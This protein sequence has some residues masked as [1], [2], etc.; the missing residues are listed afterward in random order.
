MET[1]PLI[2]ND[3]DKSF[4]HAHGQ[5]E[6]LDGKIRSFDIQ[7]SPVE[8]D[9]R[10]RIALIIQETTDRDSLKVLESYNHFKNKLLL[11]LSHELRTP[12]NGAI[13]FL[14][15]ASEDP[16]LPAHIKKELLIP[17]AKSNLLLMHIVND[18]LD[19]CQLQEN[20]LTLNL[21]NKSLQETVEKAVYLVQLQA[22]RKHLKLLIDYNITGSAQFNTDHER[23]MQVVLNL[24]NNSLKFTYKGSI[25]LSIQEKKALDGER[26]VEV[27]VADT[28]IGMKEEVSAKLLKMLAPAKSHEQEASE[29]STKDIG[30]GAYYCELALQLPEFYSPRLVRAEVYECIRR[31]KRIWFT[32]NEKQTNEELAF[33][34][35]N[36]A[37]N[38]K[39]ASMRHYTIKR[40]REEDC[41]LQRI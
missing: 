3:R 13:A 2:K 16:L 8:V 31:G 32:L 1:Y 19:F 38:R 39:R 14:D 33:S 40:N 26:L 11:S 27:R 6:L 36:S 23:L 4:F 9:G 22:E 34:S 30:L 29:L 5:M 20:N 18:M 25:T 10:F 12:L 24:L 37:V 35:L 15:R 7:V 21:S 17:A 41:L 28:G